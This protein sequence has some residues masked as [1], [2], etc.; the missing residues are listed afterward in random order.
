MT[1][2]NEVALYNNNTAVDVKKAAWNSLAKESQK[3]YQSD[4]KL[5]FQFIKKDPKHITAD[6]ILS[7][8][9]HLRDRGMK[10]NTINRKVASLSKMFK[11][12]ILAGEMQTNPVAVLKEFKNISM[13]VSKEVKISITIDDVRKATRI[14]K[15]DTLH[16][17]KTSLIVRMLAMTGLRISEC[18][19]IKNAD[20][21]DHDKSNKI[22]R[23]VGKGLK[24]RYIYIDNVFLKEIKQIFPDTKKSDYLFYTVFHRR[25]DRSVLHRQI[26]E[27]FWT[28]IQKDVWPHALRHC[29]ATHKIN[30]EKQDIKAVSRFLGHSDVSITLNSYVDT[31]LDVNKAK[32][33]I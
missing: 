20:I 13:K 9:E 19:G 16:T 8:V 32:I 18:T 27:F 12:A 30:V 11:V 22:I 31:A 10:N 26:K 29:F 15:I 3:S 5:F 23:I 6:D 14:K 1:K 24:E 4:Y 28:R 21:Q 7:Y 17:R 2:K 25:H 33:K